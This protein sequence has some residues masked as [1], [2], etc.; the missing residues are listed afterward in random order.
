MY[1]SQCESWGPSYL[2]AFLPIWCPQASLPGEDQDTARHWIH[3]PGLLAC[4]SVRVTLRLTVLKS[5][6]QPRRLCLV[7]CGAPWQGYF[8]PF[9]V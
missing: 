3:S 5:V 4:V 8:L 2:D 6:L 1:R 9:W 7:A